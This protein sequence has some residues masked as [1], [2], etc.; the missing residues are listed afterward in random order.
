MEWRQKARVESRLLREPESAWQE[1]ELPF[2]FGDKLAH[3]GMADTARPQSMPV[4]HGRSLSDLGADNRCPARV[5]S[6]VSAFNVI[7]T[8]VCC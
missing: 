8:E 1:K 5:G 3:K 7:A 2:A 4:A 6:V